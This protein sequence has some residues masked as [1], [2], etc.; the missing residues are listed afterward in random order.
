MQ[1]CSS[2]GSLPSLGGRHWDQRGGGMTPCSSAGTLPGLGGSAAWLAGGSQPVAAAARCAVGTAMRVAQEAASGCVSEVDP[3]EFQHLTTAAVSVDRAL[4]EANEMQNRLSMQEARY[5]A[6]SRHLEKHP[7]ERTRWEPHMAQLRQHLDQCYA[8]RQ[9]FDRS[10][11]NMSGRVKNLTREIR[12]LHLLPEP[13]EDGHFSERV[14]NVELKAMVM[15]LVQATGSTADEV[16]VTR[17]GMESLRSHF[18]S[19]MAK[20]RDEVLQ[21]VASGE[22]NIREELMSIG[23]AVSAAKDKLIEAGVSPGG[24][25]FERAFPERQEVQEDCTD[26]TSPMRQ[27]NAQVVRAELQALEARLCAKFQKPLDCLLASVNRQHGARANAEYSK[28]NGDS[29]LNRWELAGRPALEE[30]LASFADVVNGGSRVVAPSPGS[31]AWESEEVSY[32][33]E[34]TGRIEAL[35]NQVRQL[36]EYPGQFR[37][38]LPGQLNSAPLG[39]AGMDYEHIRGDVAALGQRLKHEQDQMGKRIEA[40]AQEAKDAKFGCGGLAA[41]L[42]QLRVDM[43]QVGMLREDLDAVRSRVARESQHRGGVRLDLDSL[44]EDVAALAEQV[45]SSRHFTRGREPTR[46]EDGIMRQPRVAAGSRMSDEVAEDLRWRITELEARGATSGGALRLDGSHDVAQSLVAEM[47]ECSNLR[48]QVESLGQRLDSELEEA[49]GQTSADWEAVHGEIATLREDVERDVMEFVEAAGKDC[50]NVRLEMG[51]LKADMEADV[52]K[53]LQNMSARLDDGMQELTELQ[54]QMAEMHSTCEGVEVTRARVARETKLRGQMRLDLDSYHEEV[55]ALWEELQQEKEA[56]GSH[57]LE[58]RQQLEDLAERV[59][60][61]NK[62][63]VGGQ[64]GTQIPAASESLRVQL[65]NVDESLHAEGEVL[66]GTPRSQAEEFT[67]NTPRSSTPQQ[68]A[69]NEELTL[70]QDVDGLRQDVDQLHQKFDEGSKTLQKDKEQWAKDK[71]QLDMD[72]RTFKANWMTE[73]S[74]YERTKQLLETVEDKVERVE[75]SFVQASAA[76]GG[77]SRAP[78]HFGSVRGSTPD[79]HFGSVR[80]T[81]MD[82]RGVQGVQSQGFL[83]DGSDEV[84]GH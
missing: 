23:A 54:R 26:G 84:D 53:T 39:V 47:R 72:L 49:R 40:V 74:V 42:C 36:R 45:H 69:P 48:L 73:T 25:A 13:D 17:A 8:D 16:A 66:A 30:Q 24:T 21:L 19:G 29:I 33:M 79:V 35:E 46:S 78:Q 15:S 3:E 80:E 4:Y 27:H 68:R 64:G 50:G 38:D 55:G 22:R 70:R 81:D 1:N 41:D 62:R 57:A 56:N 51:E 32:R 67:I 61:A 75:T 65:A 82:L 44:R 83:S 14:D 5:V 9:E 28:A 11:A 71:Q 34:V 6:I 31:M 10:A 58:T 37:G 60:L 76:L 20:L 77:E 12:R 43:S 18:R 52:H 63:G 2:A 59:Q 7:E